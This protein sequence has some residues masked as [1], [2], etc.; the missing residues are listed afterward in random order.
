L[1]NSFNYG[2]KEKRSMNTTIKDMI[3]RRSCRNYKPEQITEDELSLVLKAG[4]YAPT[5][6]GK[7]S[8]CIVA[9]QNREVIDQLSKMNADIFGRPDMDPFFGAPTVLVVLVD[10]NCHN[11]YLYDG[12][13]VMANLLNAAHALNLGSC[14]IHRARQEFESDAGK[15]LLK[16]WGIEG[17][18]EGIGHCIL[19]YPNGD[20]PVA[21]D[22]KE[23]Y[24][25]RIK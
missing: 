18:Y 3:E 17:D 22:R 14:W 21:K 15:L 5:G 11:T 10:K 16:Q 20:L 13:C 2:K 1:I 8:P 25:I 12:S 6:M 9:V 24:V 19:G 4:M 7:Q 23:N